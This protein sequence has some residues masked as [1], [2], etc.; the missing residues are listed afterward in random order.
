FFTAAPVTPVT[1]IA[2]VHAS[3][4]APAIDVDRLKNTLK[5]TAAQK[6]HWPAVASALHAYKQTQGQGAGSA[7]RTVSFFGETAAIARLAVAAQPL[8]AVLTDAQKAAA[9]GLA[10]EWGLGR[11]VMAALS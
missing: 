9:R 7:A 11:G 6:P 4:A 3:E 10:A 1:G 8:I 2:P 5:L